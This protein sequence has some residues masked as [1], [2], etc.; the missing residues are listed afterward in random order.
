[1][2][3]KL[4]LFVSSNS[5]SCFKLLYLITT[6]MFRCSIVICNCNINISVLIEN[7]GELYIIALV[8]RRVLSK[9]A[10]HHTHPHTQTQTLTHT[11]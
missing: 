10:L 6:S 9:I 1:M 2:L 3:Q 5:S 8:E 4:F 11:Y 7:A